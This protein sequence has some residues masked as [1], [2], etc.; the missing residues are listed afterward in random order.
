MTNHH[1]GLSRQGPGAPG[2]S[3]HRAPALSLCSHLR[4]KQSARQA[5]RIPTHLSALSATMRSTHSEIPFHTRGAI[6]QKSSWTHYVPSIPPARPCAMLGAGG[7]DRISEQSCRRGSGRRWCGPPTAAQ[8]TPHPVATDAA[9]CCHP[10]NHC[11]CTNW[12]LALPAAPWELGGPCGAPDPDTHVVTSGRLPIP[13]RRGCALSGRVQVPC[14]QGM[15]GSQSSRSCPV[16]P[17]TWQGQQ[18]ATVRG[19]P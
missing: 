11:V 9:G 18:D 2:T 4:E 5:S 7:R 17:C 16:A 19:G 1:G 13:S 3:L 12:G 14:E 8:H 10:T 15:Q 6:S